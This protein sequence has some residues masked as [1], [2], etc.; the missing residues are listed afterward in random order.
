MLSRAR[1]CFTRRTN[2]K[3]DTWVHGLGH[4]ARFYCWQQSW[5][6]NPKLH[7]RKDSRGTNGLLT[8]VNSRTWHIVKIDEVRQRGSYISWIW[9]FLCFPSKNYTDSV[10]EIVSLSL[11]I[12]P[13]RQTFNRL[14]SC[15]IDLP[16]F[17]SLLCFLWKIAVQ[18]LVMSEFVFQ[19]GIPFLSKL[20]FFVKLFRSPLPIPQNLRGSKPK[21][22]TE[23]HQVRR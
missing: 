11:S 19:N 15:C 17:V 16:S 6:A 1:S 18:C 8:L 14:E 10:W 23:Y 22:W 2:M 12:P 3:M 20:D 13:P 21:C 9:V 5:W 4:L 7:L